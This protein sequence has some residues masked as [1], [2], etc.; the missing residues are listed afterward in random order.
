MAVLLLLEVQSPAT[1]P[2]YRSPATDLGLPSLTTE[3]NSYYFSSVI[4]ERKVNDDVPA[5]IPV[6]AG[7]RR[8][9]QVGAQ[10][11]WSHLHGGDHRHLQGVARPETRVQ[12]QEGARAGGRRQAAPSDHRHLQVPRREA[13]PGLG[14][15]L[16]DHSADG[17]CRGSARPRKQHGERLDGQS[18]GRRG[19]AEG[20]GRAGRG[21]IP[22]RLEQHRREDNQQRVDS[23]SADDVG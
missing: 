4:R 22:S 13:R 6:A 23:L 12:V 11:G 20:D 18:A 21:S 7:P 2:R 19:A 14:R 17:G 15:P 5:E 1:E 8:G 3:L 9:R 10:G 16:D